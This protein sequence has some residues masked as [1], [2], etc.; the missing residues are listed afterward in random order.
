MPPW[1]VELIKP[2][3]GGGVLLAVLWLF[4]KIMDRSRPAID[5]VENLNES[6]IESVDNLNRQ[7]HEL[8]EQNGA[9]RGKLRLA[10]DQNHQLIK[11]IQYS[12]IE[13]PDTAFW[14]TDKLKMVER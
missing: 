3:A 8:E 13:F 7:I 1:L 4:S 6:L 10:Q 14:W 2:A 12:T 11:F 5:V 9:L